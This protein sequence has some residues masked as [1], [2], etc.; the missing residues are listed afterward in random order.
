M[1]CV[2]HQFFQLHL[3]ERRSDTN[4]VSTFAVEES[5]ALRLEDLQPDIERVIVSVARQY[6]DPSCYALNRE[7]LVREGYGKLAHLIRRDVL[8]KSRSRVEF[9]AQL[10]TAVKNHIISLV[11]KHRFTQKRMGDSLQ[12]GGKPD[13]CLDEALDAMQMPSMDDHATTEWIAALKNLLSPLE[14]LVLDEMLAP[15]DA[16]MIAAHFD[17]Q[18]G[19]EVGQ[20]LHVRI[21]TRHQASAIGISDEDFRTLR[22][23]I[24]QKVALMDQNTRYNRALALLQKAFG[25][26]VPHNIDKMII[27]R[28]FTLCARD[29]MENITPEIEDALTQVGARAPQKLPNGTLVCFGVL[30]QKDDEACLGCALMDECR[31]TCAMHG[32]GEIPLSS[33]VLGAR[34]VRT[35]HLQVTMPE[36]TVHVGGDN[37]VAPPQQASEDTESTLSKAQFIAQRIC[38]TNRIETAAVAHL[39]ETL[40]CVVYHREVYWKQPQSKDRTRLIFWA[41]PMA[42]LGAFALRFCSVSDA[43]K[44]KL[45]K[46]ERSWYLPPE[47]S[48]N[49]MLELLNQHIQETVSREEWVALRTMHKFRTAVDSTTQTFS[50]ATSVTIHTAGTS[51]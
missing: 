20:P 16:A 24:R 35:A 42:G 41:G 29:Q 48:E 11:T 27:R 19:R 26:E 8:T 50:E 13:V 49:V 5:P 21:C 30:W 32:L 46:H 43:L 34:N 45:L 47:I 38:P 17:A 2:A 36:T 18:R 3:Q 6:E 33:T 31:R 40:R 10:K 28:L 12:S 25:V 15:S 1:F 9:F 23:N 4:R 51:S 14:R 39:N 7:D 37:L 22:K 44:P